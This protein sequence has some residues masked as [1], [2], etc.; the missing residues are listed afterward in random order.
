V[1]KSL[2]QSP[3]ATAPKDG[4][5]TQ[6]KEL[7][8]LPETEMV[9]QQPGMST[10]PAGNGEGTGAGRGGSILQGGIFSSPKVEG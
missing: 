9:G 4:Q 10:A 1:P 5:S 3:D 6:G 8:R 2:A 7:P